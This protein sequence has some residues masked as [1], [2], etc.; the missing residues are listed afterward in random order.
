MVKNRRLFLSRLLL[1][2]LCDA[3]DCAKLLKQFLKSRVCIQAKLFKEQ[4][5]VI[6]HRVDCNVIKAGFFETH[7]YGVNLSTQ[8]SYRLSKRA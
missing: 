2:P 3:W 5:V 6:H 4:L 7:E 1:C 8:L